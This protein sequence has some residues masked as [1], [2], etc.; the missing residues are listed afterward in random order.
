MIRFLA[1]FG[2]VLMAACTNP[3][4]LDEAPAYLGNFHLGHNVVVAPN[5]TKGP[6]SREASKEEWIAAMTE[7]MTDR[8]GR[9]EGT[10]LYHIGVSVEGYVLAIP[11]VPLVASPKSALIL[12]VTAWDDAKG[13]KLNTKPHLVTVVESFS[14]NTFL[15]SGLTQSKETQMLNLSR[16]AAKQIQN[17]LVQQNNE[18]GW[19]EDDGVPANDKERPEAREEAAPQGETPKAEAPTV[20]ATESGDSPVPTQTETP[21]A[22]DLANA[23]AEVIE[24]PEVVPPPED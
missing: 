7:A 17:W 15:G 21:N 3:N 1:L 6:A 14:G 16:N 19:F 18:F 8:F 5:L 10:K 12:N 24:E 4:D 11:G 22:A 9:Y 23:A 20:A 2:L 13:G